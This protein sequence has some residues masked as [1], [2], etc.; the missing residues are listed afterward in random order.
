MKPNEKKYS[1]GIEL[2]KNLITSYNKSISFSGELYGIVEIITEDI[3]LAHRI[4][5]PVYYVL[6]RNINQP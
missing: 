4:L 3:S 1:L 5:N 2:P 6:K